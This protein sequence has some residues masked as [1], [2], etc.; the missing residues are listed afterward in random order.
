MPRPTSSADARAEE[1]PA[2]ADD[3]QQAEHGVGLHDADGLARHH[4]LVVHQQGRDAGL[5]QRRILLGEVAVDLLHQLDGV[6]LALLG[7]RQHHRRAAVRGGE[8][9]RLDAGA[10]GGGQRVERHLLARVEGRRHA[11]PRQVG[12]IDLL[13]DQAHQPLVLADAR[14]AGEGVAE[15]AADAIGDVGGGDAARL[16]RRR[17]E[18]DAQLRIVQAVGVDPVDARHALDVVAQILRRQ[19]QV[20][21]VGRPRHQHH[22]RREAVRGGDLDDARLLGLRRQL[23]VGA[24]LDLAA[25]VVHPLVEDPL[26]DIRETDQHRGDALAA[27][28]SDELD[29]GDALDGVLQRLGDAALDVLGR[30]AGQGGGDD[31]PV[32]VDLRVA[33]ARHRRI[34]DEAEDQHQG[35]GDIR[36]RV[37]ADK[38]FEQLHDA[39]G[40]PQGS[41]RPLGGQRTK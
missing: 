6:H 1:Q 40:P 30:G 15:P 18:L 5:G 33:F 34:G 20:L 25:Q 28:G 27:V 19:A 10:R 13:A 2:D 37:V 21:V 38:A 11:Q 32:E 8:A 16:G 23:D 29:V 22:R 12:R 39:A 9:V 24:V 3:D 31:H 14:L 7:H 36:Q 26:A 4:R 17:Q 41:M 35:E